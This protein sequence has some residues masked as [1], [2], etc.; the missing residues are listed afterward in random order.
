MVTQVS[1]EQG[2]M[3]VGLGRKGPNRYLDDMTE[4]DRQ[5]RALLNRAWPD[6][7]L[8]KL[9]PQQAKLLEEFVAMKDEWTEE[10]LSN[11]LLEVEIYWPEDLVPLSRSW[12]TA[13]PS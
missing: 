13:P 7:R 12:N 3:N 1:G 11:L 4:S 6:E 9:G 5:F 8:A 2:E 10:D